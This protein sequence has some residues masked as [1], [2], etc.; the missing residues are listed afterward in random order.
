[1]L[2]LWAFLPIT[3]R[4]AVSFRRINL[5]ILKYKNTRWGWIQFYNASFDGCLVIG[6]NYFVQNN[7]CVRREDDMDPKELGWQRAAWK[8]KMRLSM[9]RMGLQRPKMSIWRYPKWSGHK[10]RSSGERYIVL[11]KLVANVVN[12]TIGLPIALNFRDKMAQPCE[13]RVTASYW[14]ITL[15]LLVNY[16]LTIC[17]QRPHP[18]SL[19]LPLGVF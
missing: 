8:M 10:W 19:P 15:S 1:M 3:L 17:S 14:N 5:L 13:A 4:H 7:R 2:M 9:G 11:L 6:T 16:F 18:G 12:G